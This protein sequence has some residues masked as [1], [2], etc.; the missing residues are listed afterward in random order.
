[1]TPSWARDSA[2]AAAMGTSTSAHGLDAQRLPGE[3]LAR[4][5]PALPAR[6]A[7]G[8]VH[9]LRPLPPR[10]LGQRVLAQRRELLGELAA[11]GGG[12]RRGHAHVVE[13]S[14]AVVETEQQR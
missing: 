8:A 2:I 5:P 1:M 11:G 9:R 13:T 3:V 14:A 10:V 7:R 4:A 6:H 12:E